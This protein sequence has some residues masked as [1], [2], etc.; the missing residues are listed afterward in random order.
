LVC[1]AFTATLSEA[2]WPV[3]LKLP[4]KAPA[5]HVVVVGVSVPTEMLTGPAPVV[6]LPAIG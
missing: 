3:V 2:P 6:Q 5:V 4:L 1:D